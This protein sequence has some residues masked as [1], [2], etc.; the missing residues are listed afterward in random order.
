MMISLDAVY[1]I[2][3]VVMFSGAFVSFGHATD[4]RA[5]GRKWWCLGAVL[6]AGFEAFCAAVLAGLLIT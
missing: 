1:A 5:M 2:A 4:F 6:L 3:S